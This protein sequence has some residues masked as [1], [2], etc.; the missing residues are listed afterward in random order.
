[1]YIIPKEKYILENIN[2][3]MPEINL[4][5]L[6]V[7]QRKIENY[8]SGNSKD[9]ITLEEAEK[10]L[11]WVTFNARNFAVRDIPESITTASMVGKCA[12]TQ[13]INTQLMS[14]LGLDA[15]AFN[16]GDCI[17]A[18]KSAIYGGEDF[19]SSDS[20]CNSGTFCTLSSVIIWCCGSSCGGA[21][22]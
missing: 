14:S 11:D 10:F 5:E 8:T 22:W 18:E 17:N 9:G 19:C 20:I 2:P 15:K 6:E 12:P 16:L 3:Y 7:I 13:R 21:V 4:E 1:M